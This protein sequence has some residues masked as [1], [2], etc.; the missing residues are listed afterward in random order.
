[1]RCG[2]LIGLATDGLRELTARL[3]RKY[4]P[5]RN[6]KPIGSG[7]LGAGAGRPA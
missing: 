4:F 3:A 1:V 7:P 6:A 2:T 5:N